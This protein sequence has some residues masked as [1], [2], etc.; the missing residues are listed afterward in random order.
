MS[1][2]G[3]CLSRMSAGIPNAFAQFC[4]FLQSA[5]SYT[6][7]VIHSGLW[8][9]PSTSLAFTAYRHAAFLAVKS[10]TDC[11]NEWRNLYYVGPGNL[12]WTCDSGTEFCPLFWLSL[13]NYHSLKCY[14]LIHFPEDRSVLNKGLWSET[15]CHIV[16]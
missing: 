1:W 5:L 3:A 10:V 13:L 14:I 2:I 11:G 16:T 4:G 15:W 8:S 7:L 12:W 6:G 9:L